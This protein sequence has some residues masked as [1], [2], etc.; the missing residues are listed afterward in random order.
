MK[1]EDTLKNYYQV[2]YLGNQ[3]LLGRRMLYWSERKIENC[4][5]V[6]MLNSDQDSYALPQ[7]EEILDILNG[8]T[9][10]F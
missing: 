10:L 6:W 3:D 4:G 2:E 9:L 1:S 8:S 5:Y 7:T